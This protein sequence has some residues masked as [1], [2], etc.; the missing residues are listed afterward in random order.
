MDGIR[1]R[2]HWGRYN[3][4]GHHRV[5]D[6]VVCTIDWHVIFAKQLLTRQAASFFKSRGQFEF[7]VCCTHRYRIG[8]YR[9]LVSGHRKKAVLREKTTDSQHSQ[10]RKTINNGQWTFLANVILCTRLC[11]KDY[12]WIQNK[13]NHTHKHRAHNVH[14][15]THH[16]IGWW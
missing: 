16:G 10:L 1:G 12:A 7:G 14:T 3:R 6:P 15:D 13:T 5:G 11:E 4:L 9:K 8:K 2:A